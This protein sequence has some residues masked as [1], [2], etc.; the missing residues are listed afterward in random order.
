MTE[1]TEKYQEKDHHTH[2]LE[3]PDTYIGS[4]IEEEK[5]LRNLNIYFI[6]FGLRRSILFFFKNIIFFYKC[7]INTYPH[8]AF[9]LKL[10]LFCEKILT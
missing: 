1:T 10:L 2:I 6:H 8:V 9:F 3:L 5:E 4:S 7:N